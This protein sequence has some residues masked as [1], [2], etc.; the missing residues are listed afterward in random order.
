MLPVWQTL[1]LFSPVLYLVSGFRWS[2]YESSDVNVG[3]GL[4]I[5]GLFLLIC[6]AI[7]H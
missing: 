1:T 5:T 6:M 4:F 2:F 7:M 3:V